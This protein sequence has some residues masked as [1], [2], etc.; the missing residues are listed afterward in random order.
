MAATVLRSKVSDIV[1]AVRQQ[2]AAWGALGLP[3][4]RILVWAGRDLPPHTQAEQDLV[5]KPRG[6]QPDRPITDAAGRVDFRVRRRLSVIVRTRSVVD[7]ADRS[8]EWLE[9]PNAGHFA[10]E[11]AVV[12][13]LHDF[14]PADDA[15]NL[16]TIEPVK[17]VGSGDPEQETKAEPGWGQSQLD[18]ELFYELPLDQ[19]SQ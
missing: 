17:F 3:V 6:M 11:E 5:L 13:A 8:Q 15:G 16:L 1:D 10:F 4:E 12:D 14:F 18:F 7:D 2:L 9:D 19:S